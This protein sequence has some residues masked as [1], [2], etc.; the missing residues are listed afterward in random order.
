MVVLAIARVRGSKGIGLTGVSCGVASGG[1]GPSAW[2]VAADDTV[3]GSSTGELAC[4]ADCLPC[5]VVAL[6]VPPAT[7]LPRSTPGSTCGRPAPS[8]VKAVT[9]A[10]VGAASIE[11]DP[12]PSAAAAREQPPWPAQS[13]TPPEF[14]SADAGRTGCE[15]GVT[16]GLAPGP[17]APP[18]LPFFFFAPA[19]VGRGPPGKSSPAVANKDWKPP[20]SSGLLVVR[21]T[22][23]ACGGIVALTVA[24][25][26]GS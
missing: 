9:D 4:K 26:R 2:L 13:G 6:S 19:P 24:S 22:S 20:A 7:S 21:L 5:A 18:G 3:S 8:G 25:T 14:G 10:H 12:L 16:N 17:A 11:A 15:F 23:W 1:N